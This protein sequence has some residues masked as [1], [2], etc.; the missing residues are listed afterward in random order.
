MVL[1]ILGPHLG[2]LF[3]FCEKQYSLKTVCMIGIQ[4]IERMESLHEKGFIH[5]DVKPDNFLIGVGK[6]A[7]TVYLIDF[8]LSKRYIDPRTGQHTS[9]KENKGMTGT[10]R[11][12]SLNA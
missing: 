2:N 4:C 6:K 10:V 7:G 11:Y 3:K 8:G 12:A 5:R 1:D 9:F